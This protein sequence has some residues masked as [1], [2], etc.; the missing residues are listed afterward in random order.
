MDEVKTEKHTSN[1]S[2][3]GAFCPF[4]VGV[5]FDAEDVLGI[6]AKAAKH[7]RTHKHPVSFFIIFNIK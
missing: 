3:R 2:A 7:I 4:I 6:W 5:E 1:L